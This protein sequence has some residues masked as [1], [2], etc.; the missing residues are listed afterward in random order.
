M[1][2]TRS[3]RYKERPGG[4][5]TI[6][7]VGSGDPGGVLPHRCQLQ[8][9]HQ[10]GAWFMCVDFLSGQGPIMTDDSA[11]R[12]ERDDHAAYLKYALSLAA[13]SPPKPTNYRVG[14]VLVDWASNEVLSTGYTLELPGNTHAEQCCFEKLATRHH[15]EASELSQVLPADT[16]LYTTMEP[17]SFRLSGNIPCVERILQIGDRIKTVYVGVQEP[18]KFVKENSGSRQLK[19]AGIQV[20]HVS[21]LESEILQIATAGHE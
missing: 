17:C 11:P 21:G 14:A 13:N 15:I 18:E 16:I 7:I 3:R 4:N 2:W 20:V 12:I 1:C 5:P 8:H 9:C 19:D 6:A 10:L